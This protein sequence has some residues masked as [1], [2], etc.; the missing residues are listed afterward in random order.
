MLTQSDESGSSFIDSGKFK[1]QTKKDSRDKE[2]HYIIIKGSIFQEDIAML[3]V[4]APNESVKMAPETWVPLLVGVGPID[5]AK[6][7][8]GRRKDLLL[9]ASTEN[10]GDLSQSSVSPTARLGKFKA[11][12]ACIFMRGVEHGVGAKVN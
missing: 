12:G 2:E 3:N 6:A 10:M 4:L 9:A 5:I 1:F 7:K 8:T 11:K